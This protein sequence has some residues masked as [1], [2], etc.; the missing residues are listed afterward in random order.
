MNIHNS[1]LKDLE[2]INRRTQIES[3]VAMESFSD[4]IRRIVPTMRAA[5]SSYAETVRTN[6][7]FFGKSTAEFNPREFDQ[8]VQLMNKHDHVNII[9][10]RFYVPEGFDGNIVSYVELLDKA[11]EHANRVVGDA[12]TP[13]NVYLSRL[14]SD[15][16]APAENRVELTNLIKMKNDREVLRQNLEQYFPKGRT[17]SSIKLGDAISRKQDWAE[18][19]RGLKTLSINFDRT[20]AK[21]VTDGMNHCVELLEALSDTTGGGGLDDI[22]AQQLRVLGDSTLEIA[23]EVEFFSIVNY[24]VNSLMATMSQNIGFLQKALSK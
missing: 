21:K 2:L 23:K 8:L 16:S 14:L 22:S 18:L 6:L 10:L 20:Q 7:G 11:L 13:Y 19:A 4:S 9:D 15:K 3:G 5:I 24:Q 1:Q 12:L 17:N